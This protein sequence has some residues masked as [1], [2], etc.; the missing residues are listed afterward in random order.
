[1]TTDTKIIKDISCNDDFDPESLLVENAVNKILSVAKEINDETEI[2]I[3]ESLGRI[4][5]KAVTAT[6]NVPGHTNSAM[7]GYAIRSHDIPS[8]DFATLRV[9]GTSWAGKPF[10]KKIASGECARIM[11]GAALPEGTDTIVMQE[12]VKI[13]NNSII[14]DAK[15]K[16]GQNVRYAGEDIKKGALVLNKGKKISAADMGLLA[17]IGVKKIY[18]KRKIKVS[19]FSTGDELAS[20]DDSLK[21]GQ[22]Y[23][24]NRYTLCG[25]LKNINAKITDLGNIPDNKNKI[26]DTLIE[27]SKT[28]DVV[29]TSGGVSVGDADYVK[30]IVSE[31]G[32]VNFWKVAMKPGRPLAFGK[33]NNTCFFGL[34]GNPVSVMVTFYMFVQPALFKMMGQDESNML[35]LQVRCLDHLRKRPGRVE[36]Q[37]GVMS[38]N[39]KNLYEVSKTGSQGSGILTSMSEANCFIVLPLDAES[40]KPGDTVT[41]IPFASLI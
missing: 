27:A 7:D 36:F 31:I 25:M 10:N 26:K 1:M 22:I 11:T 4:L 12:H 14:I 40:I 29:I 21:K 18:A 20:L 19:Y 5:N 41:V 17:S 6:I 38:L 34:P 2:E 33:I 39:D 24:S 9:T 32:E 16:P 35:R 8:A 13:E 23:N 28:S 30:D 15:N 37:R 3:K